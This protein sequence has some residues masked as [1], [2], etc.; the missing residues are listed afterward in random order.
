MYLYQKNNSYFAQMARELIPDGKKELSWLGATDLREEFRGIKFKA[1]KASLYRI[2]YKSRFATRILAP[3]SS[4]RCQ[5]QDELYRN[6]R[7]VKWKD[8]LSTDT[9]FAIFANVSESSINNSHFASLR[10]KD[11]VADY[12]VE[13]TGIR[14]NVETR[15]PDLWINLHIRKDFATISIDTSG[16]S[17]HKRGYR[18][19]GLDAPMQETLAAE[20]IQQTD[21]DTEQPLADPMCGSGTL[22]C[23]ALMYCANIPSG[24]LRQN[25]GFRHLPDFKPKI[26]ETIL[27]KSRKKIFSVSKGL[28][29]GSDISE[30]A[31]KA[32]RLNLKNIP[33]GDSVKIFRAPFDEL[34]SLESHLIVTNPPYGIRLEGGRDLSGF[35]KSLGDFLKNKCKGSTAYV[36]FGERSWLKAIGLKPSWKKPLKN[37]GLDGRLAKFELY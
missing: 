12:F 17:L 37:G 23:E 10:L 7:K 8:F 16:G 19:N 4:F 29:T 6:G 13:T 2:N 14:P 21:W 9:T 11:A 22:L 28:I 31:V 5:N 18:K 26:W 33:G 3:L 27:E 32:A 34:N 25:F 35:Y 1:D 36:Y 24:Y 15:R 20:I 30:A